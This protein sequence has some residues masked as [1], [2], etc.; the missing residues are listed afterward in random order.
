MNI[1]YI[2]LENPYDINNNGGIGTYTGVIAEGMAGIGNKV[3]IITVGKSCFYAVKGVKVHCISKAVTKRISY[4]EQSFKIYAKLLDIMEECKIDIIEAPE[5]FAQGYVCACE[6]GIPLITRLHTPLFLIENISNGQKI[7]RDSSAIKNF[8]RIQGIRSTLMTSPCSSLNKLVKDEWGRESI[9]VPNPIDVNKYEMGN[10]YKENQI[11]YMGRLEYRKGVL[12]L[13][14]SLSRVFEK[15]RDIHIT[16]CGKDTFYKKKSV[17]GMFLDRC[18]GYESNIEFIEHAHS[19]MKKKLIKDAK[20]IVLPSVWENFSYVALEAMCMGKT[21]I[22]SA[23]GGFTEMIEDGQSGYLVPPNE[24]D[25][26]SEL[27]SKVMNDTIPSTGAEARRR[28]EKYFDIS[29]LAQ[30][31]LNIYNEAINKNVSER[32]LTCRNI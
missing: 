1:V 24:P 14:E 23:T 11:L 10:S 27:I 2:T 20:L 18:R 32:G 16:I 4:L 6:T 3:H 7:Y 21:I 17:K 25:A 31:Y 9:V 29:V 13:A 15:N 19:D 26:F 28:V 5:W 22:A 30:T 8:E 12:N